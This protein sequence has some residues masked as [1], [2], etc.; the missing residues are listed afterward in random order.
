V[1]GLGV[2][3]SKPCDG[4]YGAVAEVARGCDGAEAFA[5]RSAEDAVEDFALDEMT[6]ERYVLGNIEKI[7]QS[8]A[9]VEQADA[10]E[11]M[12]I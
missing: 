12:G 4:A 11:A 5:L 1:Q 7:D 9:G 6:E 3:G 2:V 8:G 10:V